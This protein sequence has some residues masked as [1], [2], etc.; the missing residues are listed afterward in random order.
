MVAFLLWNVQRK[1][2]DS[3]VQN[4]VHQHSIDVVLLVEYAFGVSQLPF[5]LLNDGLVKRSSSPKFGVFLR[6]THRLRLL[7]Y[8]VGRRAN[9][10][11]WVPALGPGGH[12]RPP[13]RH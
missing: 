12:P 4:L 6:N 8:G 9:M 1:P 3:L 5:L 10:W 7:R 13:A 2:L 11:R